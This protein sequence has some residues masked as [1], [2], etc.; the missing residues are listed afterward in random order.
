MSPISLQRQYGR[1]LFIFFIFSFLFVDNVVARDKKVVF[2]RENGETL[3]AFT[4]EL[5]VTE[6]EQ[7]KGLMFRKSMP[8]KQGML[9]IYQDEDIRCY[10]MKNTYIPLDIIFIDSGLT[11][12]DIYRNA[13]PLDETTIVSRGKAKYVLEINSGEADRCRIKKGTKLSIKE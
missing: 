10:W 2:F 13:K 9:F 12:V 4:V 3:C 1:I 11:V 8:K 6:Y 7:A 5:A